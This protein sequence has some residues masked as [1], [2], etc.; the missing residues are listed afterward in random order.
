[1]A[2]DE[3][4]E[5][6]SRGGG[7]KVYLLTTRS[8]PGESLR[9]SPFSGEKQATHRLEDSQKNRKAASRETSVERESGASIF[10]IINMSPRDNR[11]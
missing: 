3:K 2:Y 9:F 4:S 7:E 6:R 1:M 8:R 10:Y 11:F 5:W